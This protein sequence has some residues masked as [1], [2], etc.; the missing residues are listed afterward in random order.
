MQ[1]FN[2]STVKNND[3]V[4][5]HLKVTHLWHDQDRL[6]IVSRENDLE[7]EKSMRVEESIVCEHECSHNFL[8]IE[9]S[10][11][12]TDEYSLKL[13]LEVNIGC[14][15]SLKEIDLSRMNL[16]A[17]E[18]NMYSILEKDNSPM[19]LAKKNILELY[20]VQMTAGSYLLIKEPFSTNFSA[21][22]QNQRNQLMPRLK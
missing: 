18:L 11:F 1:N 22:G 6:T 12:E 4:S 17:S 10:A 8:G 9:Q 19:N 20:Q 2:K 3:P 15:V 14:I 5:K 16:I 21:L 7:E 13:G